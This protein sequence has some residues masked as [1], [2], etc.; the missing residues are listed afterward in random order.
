M[1]SCYFPPC[2]TTPTQHWTLPNLP[3]EVALLSCQFFPEQWQPEH[4]ALFGLAPTNAIAKRQSEYLAGRFCAREALSH[5]GFAGVLVGA[6]E[7]RAPHWP[8]N[9]TGSITHSQGFAV[10]LAAPSNV[11]LSAGIDLEKELSWERAAKVAK[12]VH[13]PS[14]FEHWQTLT[15]QEQCFF[16]TLAFSAKESLYKA[17]HPLVNQSFFFQ[18]AELVSYN[19]HGHVSLRLRKTLSP[20]WTANTLI[21]GLFN[22]Q[23]SFVLT[24][25]LIAQP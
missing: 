18:D 8:D 1:T 4:S 21:E 10:A 23:D 14:E 15:P 7:H 19:Q 20:A 16:T 6:T 13:T 3:E 22:V 12:H 9:T 11:L 5:L 17:L 24:A 25:V 2:C